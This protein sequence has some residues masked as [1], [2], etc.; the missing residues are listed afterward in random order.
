[1]PINPP[2]RALR[3]SK[4]DAPTPPRAADSAALPARSHACG[5]FESSYELQA[6]LSLVEWAHEP[7]PPPQPLVLVLPGERC[8]FG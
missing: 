6:G 5:W 2:P 4:S 1:M 3:S 8:R 7:P